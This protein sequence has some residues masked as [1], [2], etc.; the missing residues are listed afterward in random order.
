MYKTHTGKCFILSNQRSNV[1]LR[2]NKIFSRVVFFGEEAG[3]FGLFLFVH[4]EMDVSG[5]DGASLFRKWSDSLK[6]PC[7]FKEA[8]MADA[9]LD[10]FRVELDGYRTNIDIVLHKFPHIGYFMSWD[11]CVLL[12]TGQLL[13]LSNLCYLHK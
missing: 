4:V 1:R 6:G 10:K 3:C 8:A 12:I 2:T 7:G 13:P 9:D 11:R 5:V